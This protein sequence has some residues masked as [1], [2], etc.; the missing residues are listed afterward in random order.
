MRKVTVKSEYLGINNDDNDWKHHAFKTTLKYKG[1]QMTVPFKMGTGCSGEPE[2]DTVMECL[3]S[4]AMLSDYPFG[5]WAVTL[6][7]NPDSR[8]AEG[9][10]NQIQVQTK[11]LHNLLGD[12]F[13]QF[14]KKYM[15]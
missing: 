1:K 3:L 4:D 11:K 5:E 10:Y 8:K 2:V 7:Y 12:D 14:Q 15:D 9:I 13:D 6:G